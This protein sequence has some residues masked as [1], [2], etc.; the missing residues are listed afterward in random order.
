MD[1]SLTDCVWQQFWAAYVPC[2]SQYL[3]A[4]KQTLEQIDRIKRLVD[5]YPNY[6]RFAVD[7]KGMQMPAAVKSS[8]ARSS[9]SPHAANDAASCRSEK[10]AANGGRRGTHP[11]P[12]PQL[13]PPRARSFVRSPL[14]ARRPLFSRQLAGPSGHRSALPNERRPSASDRARSTAKFHSDGQK[15]RQ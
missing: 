9:Y 6:L 15:V 8:G 12:F 10:L 1:A 13:E 14:G 4:V 5:R 11:S 7:P 2:G 3:D